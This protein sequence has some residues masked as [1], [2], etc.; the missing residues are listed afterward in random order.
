MK[1]S[2]MFILLF[3]LLNSFANGQYT[4]V[5]I[6][7]EPDAP[8][9]PGLPEGV[10]N[11]GVWQPFY[12][13][14]AEYYR[15][16]EIEG[17][18]VVQHIREYIYP[19]ILINCTV[20]GINYQCEI[21]FDANWRTNTTNYTEVQITQIF[22]PDEE[23]CECDIPE[24]EDLVEIATKACFE[25]LR[26]KGLLPSDPNGIPKSGN[27]YGASIA[28][29]WTG[30]NISMTTDR[31]Y[32]RTLASVGGEGITFPLFETRTIKKNNKDKTADNEL[33]SFSTVYRKCLSTAC[34]QISLE[35]TWGYD[36][37]D[38]YIQ[39]NTTY[40]R[41]GDISRSS[42]EPCDELHECY[43]RCYALLNFE[44]ESGKINDK[45]ETT[46]DADFNGML[47]Y[48]N[49]TDGKI[50]FNL[51]SVSGN[52]DQLSIYSSEGIIIIEKSLTES[53]GVFEIDLSYFV[54]GTY[55]YILKNDITIIDSGK[56]LLVP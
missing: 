43:D 14:T 42:A 13:I 22:L 9:D 53:S 33:V 31:S 38:N 19:S 51:S 54:S 27:F 50:K 48:P 25:E 21:A 28:S 37:Y 4:D 34:C 41:V 44:E 47:I 5:H 15:I 12:E 56:F 24:F 8:C 45:E 32:F 30:D 6:P 29:C 1:K 20:N 35:I 23:E 10:S 40:K 55:F 16:V 17:G 26:S 2:F 7:F 36:D 11:V 18:L 52:V 39:E 3:V 49:P 46:N